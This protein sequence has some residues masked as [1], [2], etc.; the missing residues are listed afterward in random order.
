MLALTEWELIWDGTTY[1]GT[2]I[3][4]P[5]IPALTPIHFIFRTRSLCEGANMITFWI[6]SSGEMIDGGL[7]AK[8][9][10]YC[11]PDETVKPTITGTPTESQSRTLRPTRT[12][13]ATK[14]ESPTSVFTPTI[15]FSPPSDAFTTSDG[16]HQ[17]E[18]FSEAEK[19]DPNLLAITVMVALTL[20]TVLAIFAVNCCRKTNKKTEEPPVSEGSE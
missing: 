20:G 13:R 5:P 11:F 4:L 7:W 1:T 15:P 10:Y 19:K 16:F 17:E 14:S 3:Y 2:S 6:H 9:C 8:N 18:K 12:P